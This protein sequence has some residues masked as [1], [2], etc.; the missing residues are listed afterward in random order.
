MPGRQ[1]PKIALRRDEKNMKINKNV[2]FHLVLTR[3]EE[4]LWQPLSLRRFLRDVA[5]VEV[6]VELA[7][8]IT[9]YRGVISG[10]GFNIKN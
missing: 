3:F 2:L 7:L 6:E 10:T 4:R 5:E 9:E 8:P 1:D